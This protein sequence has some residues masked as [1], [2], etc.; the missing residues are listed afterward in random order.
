MKMINIG[1]VFENL[2]VI[3]ELEKLHH[4]RRFLCKCKCGKDYVATQEYLLKNTNHSCKSCI[5]KKTITFAQNKTRKHGESCNST[6]C[7]K[8]Y[9][10]WA[11]M[12]RRCYNPNTKYYYRYGGRGI[13]VCDKWLE[14]IPFRDWA[15]KS[16]YKE[17]LTI[18]RI[19][20]NGNYC[21]ENCEWKTIQFQQTHR[22][23]TL[24]FNNMSIKDISKTFGIKTCTLYERIRKNKNISFEDLI[25]V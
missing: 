22:C 23:N 25:K 21:P 12:K 16:G 13:K 20:N 9:G 8:L 15:M 19:D 6:K 17:G 24:K 10:V 4:R 1:D 5:S 3:S 2:T 7:S 11:S 14:Y 18:D